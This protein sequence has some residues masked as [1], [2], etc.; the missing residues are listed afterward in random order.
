MN[1]GKI[2]NRWA[3]IRTDAIDVQGSGT[4]QVII[5]QDELGD[6]KFS[7]LATGK[8][9]ARGD[10]VASSGVIDIKDK[11]NTLASGNVQTELNFRDSAG[12]LVGG[13][14]F[15]NNEVRLNSDD[16]NKPVLVRASNLRPYTDNQTSL[17]SSG[18]RYIDLNLGGSVNMRAITTPSLPAGNGL[19]LYPKFVDGETNLYTVDSSGNEKLLSDGGNA[20][21]PL[22]STFIKTISNET[23]ILIDENFIGREIFYGGSLYGTTNESV[24]GIQLTHLPLNNF[25]SGGIQYNQP[26]TSDIGVDSYDD[27]EVFFQFKISNNALTDN[28][29]T[30]IISFYLA[31]NDIS[32]TNYIAPSADVNGALFSVGY[33]PT[34]ES[35]TYSRT[36]GITH[37]QNLPFAFDSTKIYNCKIVVSGGTNINVYLEQFGTT[38]TTPRL[39][40]TDTYFNH[41]RSYIGMRHDAEGGPFTDLTV[42]LRTFSFKLKPP[43][44]DYQAKVVMPVDDTNDDLNVVYGLPSN[45]FTA[46]SVNPFGCTHFSRPLTRPITRVTTAGYRATENDYIILVDT[47]A[48]GEPVSIELPKPSNLNTENNQIEYVIKDLGNAVNQQIEIFTNGSALIDGQA[49]MFITDNFNSVSLCCDG[50]D[51]WVL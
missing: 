28:N 1:L 30:G 24:D 11:N 16:G 33:H 50:T 48:A 42:Y 10:I 34:I 35:I 51:Y 20:T 5:V 44:V 15:S 27:Y 2:D 25:Y 40:F 37:S 8:V 22:E 49:Q 6:T 41:K 12:A 45:P 13:L 43:S 26:A 21:N 36:G 19:K 31:D 7:I 29:P 39:T 38:P 17:G 14:K 18:V 46:L 9:N 4:D 47:F 23:F 3:N 32:A